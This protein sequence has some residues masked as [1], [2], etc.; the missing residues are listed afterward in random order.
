MLREIDNYF[1]NQDEPAQSCLQALRNFVLNFH[2]EMEEAWRYRM[3]CYRIKKRPF[4]YLWTDKKTH[5]PYILLVRG[6]QIDHP[7][8]SQKKGVK[9][10]RLL[11]DPNADLP[12]EDISTVFNLLLELY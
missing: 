11:V 2:P 9:M 10:K 3:P 1:L 12:V 4:C 8:L 5:E 6:A 7:A